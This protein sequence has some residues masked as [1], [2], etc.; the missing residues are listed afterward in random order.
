MPEAKT[1]V[2]YNGT[3]GVTYNESWELRAKT[4]N[5]SFLYFRHISSKRQ[6][7]ISSCDVVYYYDRKSKTISDSPVTD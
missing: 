7:S 1:F 6:C 2:F 5:P 3:P 4:G